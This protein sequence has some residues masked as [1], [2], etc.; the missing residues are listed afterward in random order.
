MKTSGRSLAESLPD[1]LFTWYF[2]S[3]S[4]ISTSTIDLL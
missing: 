2:R 1:R 4:Q 3:W